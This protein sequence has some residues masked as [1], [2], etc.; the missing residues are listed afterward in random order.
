MNKQNQWLF[1]APFSLQEAEYMVRPAAGQK[2]KLTR[3][4]IRQ[5]ILDR[6]KIAVERQPPGTTIRKKQE[7]QP[8][9]FAANQIHGANPY[10][11][12]QVILTAAIQ[13]PSGVTEKWA[14]PNTGAGWRKGQKAVAIRLG[15]KP[16]VPLV[17][18]SDIHAE[19]NLAA[20]LHKTPGSRVLRW[21]ISRGKGGTS[22]VC[23][24]CKNLS[25][26]WSGREW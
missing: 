25:K 26:G 20:Y 16:L 9:K 11:A 3:N 17:S 12:G 7:V 15:F 13:L 19:E 24:K 14:V 8:F 2:S 21:A 4:Q 10:R 23:V 1:E 22:N 5:E 6:Q 18:G